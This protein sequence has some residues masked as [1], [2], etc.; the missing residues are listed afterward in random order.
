[1]K[2]DDKEKYRL[3]LRRKT[4]SF[5]QRKAIYKKI[6][7]AC[8]KIKECEYCCAFNGVVKHVTGTDAT[9]IVHERFAK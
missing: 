4:L 7:D 2:K 1:M 5:N 8:K 6:L 9:I 3:M